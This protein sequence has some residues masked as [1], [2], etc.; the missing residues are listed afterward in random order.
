MELRIAALAEVLIPS[1]FAFSLV[2]NSVL[3][4]TKRRLFSDED[5][6]HRKPLFG[7]F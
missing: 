4:C 3:L 1:C 6:I 5:I 7:V 2:R